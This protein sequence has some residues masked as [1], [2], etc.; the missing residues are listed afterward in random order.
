MLPVRG[1]IVENP[2]FSDILGEY[3]ELKDLAEQVPFSVPCM[4]H[5][6]MTDIQT[7]LTEK[8]MAPYIE[9]VK[10]SEPLNVPEADAYIDAAFEAMRQAGGLE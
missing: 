7:A 6:K 4:P 2:I 3:P 9:L 10:Q 5:D 8:G 1:D